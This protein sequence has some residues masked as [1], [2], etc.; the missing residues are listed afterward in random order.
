MVQSVRRL[1][2]EGRIRKHKGFGLSSIARIRGIR[3]RYVKSFLALSVCFCVWRVYHPSYSPYCDDIFASASLRATPKANLDPLCRAFPYVW[4]DAT[5]YLNTTRLLNKVTTFLKTH[6]Q[7]YVLIGGALLGLV[8]HN[9]SFVPW[10]DDVDLYVRHSTLSLLPSLIER[11]SDLCYGHFWSEQI[12]IYEC[13]SQKNDEGHG[14]PAI[15]IQNMRNNTYKEL[16]IQSRGAYNDDVL[17]P[18]QWATLE[19]ISIR[20]PFRTEE[21]M[22]RYFGREYNMICQPTIWNHQFECEN[23]LDVH[24]PV[25]CAEVQ[26]RCSESWSMG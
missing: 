8:R 21:H 22:V 23:R 10:D 25:K 14:Y 19:G 11:T 13:D 17:W 3:V 7:E 12:K 26:E 6:D 16:D 20:I 9:G 18:S 4:G 24:G 1:R 15:D 2:K 5:K